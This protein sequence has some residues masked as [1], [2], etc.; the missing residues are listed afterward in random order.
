MKGPL[1]LQSP[2][3][4][5]A[6]EINEL[7]K[8]DPE[9]RV[10]YTDDD[11]YE[12]K[13]YVENPEKADALTQLLPAERV[14]G[15]IVFKTFVIP[16][17]NAESNNSADLFEKA[18]N[19]NP[20]LSFVAQEDPGLFSFPATYVVF[21]N[22]VVQFYN[23]DLSDYYRNKSTLYQEIARD[24]FG[25][26]CGVFFCTDIPEEEKEVEEEEEDEDFSEDEDTDIGE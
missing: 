9:I 21:A 2:W 15:N 4:T 3:V 12:I 16:A 24:V 14:F 11:P 25:E 26:S 10:E 1:R 5:F 6:E 7:F 22:K 20:A 19:G 13:L 23:D 8:E 17:D 18:F